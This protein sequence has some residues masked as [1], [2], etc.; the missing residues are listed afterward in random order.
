[1]KS[2]VM[3][4]HL[5]KYDSIN[6]FRIWISSKMRIIRTCDVFV[7]FYSFYDSCVSDLKHFLSTKM[8]NVI[9]ILKMFETT[10]N[11]VLT[12]QND[13]DSKKL[14]FESSF[15][16]IDE[17]IIDL[18]DF[19]IDLKD[20]YTLEE[21]QMITFEMTSNR[22]LTINNQIHIVVLFVSKIHIASKAA[23]RFSIDSIFDVQIKFESMNSQ[24]RFDSFD[25]NLSRTSDFVTMNTRSRTRKQTYATT[26]II[27][28]QLNSYFAT[29]SI[30]LQ[31][32]NIIFVVLK[33]HKNDLST[34]S[35]Y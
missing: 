26:L 1:M 22:E 10:F 2:R 8:K 20:N 12:E 11:D 6:V 14:I 13:D 18:I 19:Q 5:M 21:N 4:D 28:N 30:E 31:R 7:D 32:S 23:Q 25:S 9:Q 33:L 24:A 17:L 3:I 16:K 34:K 15:K 29:F 35:R 27:V